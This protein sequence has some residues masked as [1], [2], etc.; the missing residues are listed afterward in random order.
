MMIVM[1]IDKAVLMVI[2][3]CTDCQRRKIILIHVDWVYKEVTR[4]DIYCMDI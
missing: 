1:I 2:Q 4:G 3:L